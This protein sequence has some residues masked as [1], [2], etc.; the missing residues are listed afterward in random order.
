M[1]R[2]FIAII[3]LTIYSIPCF[4]A[5][6]GVALSIPFA[7]VPVSIFGN[8]TVLAYEVNIQNNTEQAIQ[9]LA[10]DINNDDDNTLIEYTSLDLI[11][12]VEYSN[13]SAKIEPNQKATLFVW[14]ALPSNQAIPK[15]LSHQMAYT[16]DGN[17]DD[18]RITAMDAVT[19]IQQAKAASLSPPLSGGPWL[20]SGISNYSEH[21]RARINYQD[22]GPF[23]PERYAIDWTKFD[24][25]NSSASDHR[26]DGSRNSDYYAY[27]QFVFA[28]S[29]GVVVAVRNSLA[30]NPNPPKRPQLAN[31]LDRPGNY[32]VIKT[33]EN[34]YLVYCHLQ[35][36]T[37]VIKGQQVV[38]GQR[39][40]YVGSSGDAGI[41]HLHFDVVNADNQTSPF[42]AEGLPYTYK[43]FTLL[44][45]TQN[46]SQYYLNP[47]API[48]ASPV[49]L[50]NQLPL[51]SMFVWFE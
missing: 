15:K 33:K 30:D 31:V 38:Q 9:P 44:A 20:A 51:D 8:K 34:N 49:K 27:G 3:F 7:P 35:S 19:P 6:N 10:I 50:E 24:N 11:H 40:G 46:N 48:I 23:L 26:G 37:L 13:G 41:P 1:T 18:V 29:D 17:A 22:A 4:A 32:V 39:I 5:D 36:T 21:R 28:S 45:L 47:Y 14:L 43:N 25:T 2:L 16:M 12:N 42:L